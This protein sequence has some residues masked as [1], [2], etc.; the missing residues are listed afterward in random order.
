MS[1]CVV[2]KVR[3]FVL[4]LHLLFYLLCWISLETLTLELVCDRPAQ[5]TGSLSSV[6]R[7]KTAARS[8]QRANRELLTPAN[9]RT[10]TRHTVCLADIVVIYTALAGT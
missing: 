3:L 2:K 4:K 7:T 6:A 10:D 9:F 8:Y 1:R 5:S